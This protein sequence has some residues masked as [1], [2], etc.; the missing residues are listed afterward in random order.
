MP[1]AAWALSSAAFVALVRFAEITGLRSVDYYN[2][3]IEQ[4][5]GPVLWNV[6]GVIALSFFALTLIF[7]KSKSLA[8]ISHHLLMATY[9][10]GAMTIGILVAQYFF[11]VGQLR[12]YLHDWR[13]Y[14]YLPL[15]FLLLLIVV[16]INT[17]VGYLAYLVF[18][19]RSFLTIM[20]EFGFLIRAVVG[21]GLASLVVWRLWVEP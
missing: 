13:T 7:P 18:W 14:F 20:A 1:F 19:S 10:M 6:V 4:A 11:V 3:A 8:V 2:K 17:V 12:D 21:I 15:T 5:I 9:L 16:A